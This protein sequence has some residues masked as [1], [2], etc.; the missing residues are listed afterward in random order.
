MP[1][2]KV[3]YNAESSIYRVFKGGQL[4]N[5]ALAYSSSR[6]SAF[7]AYE[8]QDKQ[9]ICPDWRAKKG[10]LTIVEQRICTSQHRVVQPIMKM[11]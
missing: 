6:S 8:R 1:S 5:K 4:K 3:D 2:Y 9:C 7:H 10:I 11:S